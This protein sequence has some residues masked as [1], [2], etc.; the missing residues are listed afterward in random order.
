MGRISK[1]GDRY[2][3]RLL[4]NGMT[5]QLRWVR[6]RPEAHPWAA[7]L[8]ARKPAKLVAVALANKAARIARAVMTRGEIYRAPQPSTQQVAP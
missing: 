1:M 8:L 5:S 2:L 6:R 7:K 4:V 3:R